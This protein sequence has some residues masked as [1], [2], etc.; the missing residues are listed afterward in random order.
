[1]SGKGRDCS[2]IAILS[3][4][5][6]FKRKKAGNTGSKTN[7]SSTYVAIRSSFSHQLGNKKGQPGHVNHSKIKYFN[8]IFTEIPPV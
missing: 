1:L 8:D 3:F 7:G 6:L 2:D 5:L 4:W